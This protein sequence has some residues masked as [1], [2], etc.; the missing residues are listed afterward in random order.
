MREQLG[1]I[2][3]LVDDVTR[4]KFAEPRARLGAHGSRDDGQYAPVVVTTN[5]DV[6]ALP[7]DMTK[8]MVTCQIDAAI[9]E[10]R[11][12]TGT[13]SG[14]IKGRSGPRHT[15]RTCSA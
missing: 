14:G 5:R 4:D 11:S 13:L 1:A 9:P 3:L 12:V 8:R 7:P 2:P 6:T 10:N 15:G